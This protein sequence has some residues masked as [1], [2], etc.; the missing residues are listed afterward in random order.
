MA[1]Y[2]SEAFIGMFRDMLR[3]ESEWFIAR[4][5]RMEQRMDSMQERLTG[6]GHQRSRSHRMSNSMFSPIRDVPRE[7]S[8]TYFRHVPTPALTQSAVAENPLVS[9]SVS[10][11]VETPII[12]Y[13]GCSGSTS[14][15]YEE[16]E[17]EDICVMISEHLDEEDILK[18]EESPT[19]ESSLDNPDTTSGVSDSNSP[20]ASDNR[21][22]SVS[23]SDLILSIPSYD[24]EDVEYYLTP[25]DSEEQDIKSYY[26]VSTTSSDQ[27][28][29]YCFSDD[30]DENASFDDDCPES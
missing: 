12:D 25:S 17:F 7:L 6:V 3:Q 13:S 15:P 11:S 27:Y 26:S 8:N 9:A 20:I 21:Y 28:Y 22:D 4:I 1:G 2:N 23:D 5:D 19:S 30:D 18:C 14:N 29:Q 24:E 16:G 10:D